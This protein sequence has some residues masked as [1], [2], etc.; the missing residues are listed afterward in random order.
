L[1]ANL[2]AAACATQTASGNVA[3]SDPHYIG[4]AWVSGGDAFHQAC[5]EADVVLAVGCRFS[6]WLWDEHGRTLLN[7]HARVIHVN[8]DPSVIGKHVAVE[9]GICADAKLTLAA[10]LAAAKHR[11]HA[12]PKHE[13]LAELSNTYAEYRAKLKKLA[14]DRGEVMHP[15][16]LAQAFADFLPPDALATFDGGHT[17]FWSND[18]TPVG[19]PRTR[20]NEPGMSQLG[21]GLPWALTLKLLHPH[22]PVFNVTGDGAFGFSLQELDTARRYGLPVVNVIHNNASWG[23]IKFGY[24]KAG[25]DF[26]SELQDTNYADIA[27][28]F[29][30]HGERVEQVEEIKPALERALRSGLP[31]VVDCAV[32]FEP[33]PCLPAFARMSAAGI[34]VG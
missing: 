18:F 3:S 16:A 33:H 34:A 19:A 4:L 28:G 21:F 27:R 7:P 25:F 9:V 24:N 8:V 6:S 20:F 1:T 10:L 22:R 23:I 29:G 26:G 11:A 13:W 2:N 31:A 14:A 17:T 5:R 12:A 32:R 15:A 30:C